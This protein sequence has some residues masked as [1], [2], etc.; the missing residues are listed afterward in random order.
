MYFT[1]SYGYHNILPFAPMINPLTLDSNKKVTNSAT[2]GISPKKIYYLIL[3]MANLA[4]SRVILK[5][6]TQ[7]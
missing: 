3:M 5:F 2:T 1:G 7:I 6:K 4:N